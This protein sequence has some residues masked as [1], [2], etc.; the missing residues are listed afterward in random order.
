M[1]VDL[2]SCTLPIYFTCLQHFVS[3]D[4][5]VVSS[6]EVFSHVISLQPTGPASKVSLR[7]KVPED[8]NSV[9]PVP[10]QHHFEKIET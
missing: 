2:D 3:D 6:W 7:N 8:D 4:H 1:T 9:L 5:S 10:D